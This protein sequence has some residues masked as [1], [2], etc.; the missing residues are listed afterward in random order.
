[1]PWQM[2][3]IRPKADET[4]LRLE[5]LRQQLDVARD[6]L[7][8]CRAELREMEATNEV[9]KQTSD[10]IETQVGAHPMPTAHLFVNEL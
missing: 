5:Q 2:L 10:T 9:M 1:M 8:R 7:E 3:A 6:S 4:N